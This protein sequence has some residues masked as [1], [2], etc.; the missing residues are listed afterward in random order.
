[1]TEKK[2]IGTLSEEKEKAFEEY[3]NK[4]FD[5]GALDGLSKAT[6]EMVLTVLTGAYTMGWV[7]C[8]YTC[9]KKITELGS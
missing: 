1:M 7:D 2:F 5:G 6:Q 8:R 3:K 9:I 4:V